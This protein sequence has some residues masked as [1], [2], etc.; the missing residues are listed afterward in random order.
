MEIVEKISSI[1]QGALKPNQARI[2]QKGYGIMLFILLQGLLVFI[3]P[4]LK[5]RH[6][7][8]GMNAV[9]LCK[10]E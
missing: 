7:S 10:R 2:L 9:C 8:Q 3:I 4:V 1:A 5:K 6:F